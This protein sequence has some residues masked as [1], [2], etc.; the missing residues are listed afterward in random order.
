VAICLFL[1]AT[2]GWSAFATIT[3]RPG[4]NGEMYLY[5]NLTQ[6]QYTIYTGLV[7]IAGLYIIF[8][9]ALYL[10]K[11]D[12]INLTKTFWKFL[13]L[14]LLIVICEIYLQTRFVGKG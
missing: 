8:F 3:E 11:T 1:F 4:L 6:L 14:L 7:A 5:Y 2:F 9:I 13:G 10:L 12:P